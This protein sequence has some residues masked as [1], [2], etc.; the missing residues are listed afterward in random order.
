MAEPFISPLLLNDTS[1]V[2]EIQED[3]IL[4]SESLPLTNHHTRHYLFTKLWL[5][6]LHRG[7]KHIPSSG[8]W[9]SVETTLDATDCNDVEIFG[10]CVVSA[11]HYTANRA[12]KRHAKLS[13]NATS[14]TFCRHLVVS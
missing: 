7:N 3:S 10:S 13:S 11:V 5:T 4:S 9:K 2:F 14:R 1:V 6:F 8:S 12:C